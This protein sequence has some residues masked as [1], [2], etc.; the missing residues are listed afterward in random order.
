MTRDIVALSIIALFAGALW[1]NPNDQMM[2]GALIGAF[3][4]VVGF[5]TGSAL[6]GKQPVTVENSANQPVPVEPQRENRS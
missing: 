2:L 6:K 4:G 3:S 1:Y 5:Y